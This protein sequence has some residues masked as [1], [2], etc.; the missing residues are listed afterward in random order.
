M[1]A[2]FTHTWLM[3]AT[4]SK[5]KFFF[6]D[7]ALASM[8]GQ[9]NGYSYL[10]TSLR[11]NSTY[12]QENGTPLWINA[13]MLGQ[14]VYKGKSKALYPGEVERMLTFLFTLA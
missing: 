5:R 10:Q 1:T 7:T 9:E 12:G 14:D 4:H 2:K 13:S 3:I 11:K 8:A 6:W